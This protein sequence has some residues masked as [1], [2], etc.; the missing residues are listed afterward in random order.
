MNLLH[1][2]DRARPFGS[3]CRAPCAAAAFPAPWGCFVL[4]HRHGRVLPARGSGMLAS[5]RLWMFGHTRPLFLP[6]SPPHFSQPQL[7]TGQSHGHMLN[8]PGDSSDSASIRVKEFCSPFFEARFDPLRVDRQAQWRGR[9]AASTRASS[10]T[11]RCTAEVGERVRVLS[12]DSA[13]PW[14]AMCRSLAVACN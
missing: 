10:W 8:P 12:Y 7:W 4:G 14:T 5:A 1:R 3:A 11:T 9:T 13:R 2:L 6:R